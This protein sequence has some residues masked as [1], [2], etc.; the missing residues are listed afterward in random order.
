MPITSLA[1][2]P[3][4]RRPTK[5]V[6][7]DYERLDEALSLIDEGHA[8]EAVHKVFAHL[9][10]TATIGDLETQP[11][12]FTQGSSRVT[13][14]IVGDQL[15]LTVPLVRLPDGAEAGRAIAALRYVLTR[16]SATGQLHQP[17]L[18]GEDLL[19]EFKDK[20]SRLHPAKLLEVLRKMPVEADSSDDWLVGQ[21]GAKP[22]DRE[23]IQ[24][25][26]DAELERCVQV[27]QT[28]WNDVEEL[29][30][31]SQRKRSLFFLNEL[32][33]YALS[34]IQ[35]VIPLTGFLNARLV[36]AAATFNSTDEDPLKRETTLSKF[37]KEMK[38]ISAAELRGNL[39][40][41][42]YAISP[43]GE[44]TPALI[45][46]YFAAGDYLESVVKLGSTGKPMDATLALVGTYTY[47][48]ARFTWPPE[49][50][51]ALKQ[52]LELASGKPW[53]EA[54]SLLTQHAKE[55]AEEF[56]GD[57]GGGDDEDEDDGDDEDDGEEGARP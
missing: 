28:H 9:F 43:L 34:R 33:A 55:L 5:A 53:R 17:R 14:R 56:G 48:L 40:H 25:V 29:V 38:A 51:A 26:N 37:A 13:A 7:P 36:E 52:G 3:P 19:L 1:Y 42:E 2:A 22:L 20:L 12:T 16:I 21:F 8:R 31:D 4:V 24:P 49:V 41:A 32:T 35:F 27:W 45:S 46:S 30:K 39:G 6:Q 50:E 18:R 54:A 23:A 11:F 10:P 57:E 47:L 44:G 15:E